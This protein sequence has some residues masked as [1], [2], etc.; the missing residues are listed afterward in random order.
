M[1]INDKKQTTVSNLNGFIQS[2]NELI[3]CKDE[4][5]FCGQK[6]KYT[7]FCNQ[8]I[9]ESVY[10]IRQLSQNLVILTKQIIK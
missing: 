1:L 9:Y 4:S 7:I 10:S 2:I 5:P 3:I 6:Y 8:P